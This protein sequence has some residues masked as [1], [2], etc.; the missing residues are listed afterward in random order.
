MET[1]SL[2]NELRDTE[3]NLDHVGTDLQTNEAMIIQMNK[4]MEILK[5]WIEVQGLLIL[6]LKDIADK[7]LEKVENGQDPLI[8][9]KDIMRFFNKESDFALRFL[10][11]AKSMGFGIQVGREY[12][13]KREEFE[14]ILST[15]QGLSLKI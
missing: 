15:Y 3:Q 6:Q 8:G 13:I 1:L 9:K 11:V 10:R 2:K 4:N 5:S 7:L 14:K 12:Y